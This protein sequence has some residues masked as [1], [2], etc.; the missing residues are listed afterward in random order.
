MPSRTPTWTRPCSALGRRAGSRTGAAWPPQAG[1]R[2]PAWRAGARHRQ[3]GRDH[4]DPGTGAVATERVPVLNAGVGVPEVP[5]PRRRLRRGQRD[6]HALGRR[7]DHTE[8]RRVADFEDAL[9]STVGAFD[10]HGPAIDRGALT[11]VGHRWVP[12]AGSSLTAASAARPSRA[13]TSWERVALTHGQVIS[14][15]TPA[16]TAISTTT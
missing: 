11:A 16:T 8:E 3:H 4:S 6:A 1:Q 7:P 5:P 13:P 2:P 15:Q 10:R 12:L 9:R 14:A